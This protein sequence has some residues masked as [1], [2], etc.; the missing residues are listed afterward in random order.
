MPD[1]EVQRDFRG[2]ATLPPRHDGA[3]RP[4]LKS[5]IRKCCRR[6]EP[7][8]GIPVFAR[9]S[10]RHASIAFTLWMNTV[11]AICRI[12]MRHCRVICVA[13]QRDETPTFLSGVSSGPLSRGRNAALLLAFSLQVRIS[14]GRWLRADSS[15]RPGTTSSN[16][17]ARRHRHQ[18]NIS[19]R[20]RGRGG[21]SREEIY[22]GAQIIQ[23]SGSDTPLQR[24]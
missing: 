23:M 8:G 18:R 21:V 9:S 22:G 1:I 4:A 2:L 7:R 12:I 6:Y 5:S 16:A 3:R 20:H 15:G 24:W 13:A 14:T 19:L 11:W 10:I 17:Q